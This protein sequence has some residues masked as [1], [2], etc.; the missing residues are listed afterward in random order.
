MAVD[1]NLQ[2][3]AFGLKMEF[4]EPQNLGFLNNHKCTYKFLYDECFA[5][6]QA[7]KP[8]DFFKHLSD[9]CWIESDKYWS[10]QRS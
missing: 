2:Y 5:F 9:I 8:V 7:T 1:R 10:I 4:D 3:L 6:V